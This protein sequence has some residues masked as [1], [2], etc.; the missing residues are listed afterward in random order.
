MYLTSPVNCLVIIVQRGLQLY[1]KVQIVR[2]YTLN[3]NT[4]VVVVVAFFFL[5]HIIKEKMSNPGTRVFSPEKGT[6]VFYRLS[7]ALLVFLFLFT[8][9]LSAFIEPYMI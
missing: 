4:L 1:F 6:S 7:L 2:T 9:A 3:H 8:P 5:N